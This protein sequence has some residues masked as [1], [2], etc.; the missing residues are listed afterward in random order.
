MQDQA[1][2]YQNILLVPRYSELTSRSK[3]KTSVIFLGRVFQ[4]PVIPAN[5]ESVIDEKI[6]KYLSENGYFYIYHR[7]S[8]LDNGH[9]STC[10]LVELAN[11]EKWKTIS[12][13]IG[14]NGN[15]LSLLDMMKSFRI[16]F[17]TIDVA[18]GH[19]IL[20]KEAIG[21]IKKWFPKTSI[22]A[23]NVATWEGVKDLALW[24]ADCVKVGIGQG[25]ICTTRFETGFSV[26]M[27]SC[28]RECSYLENWVPNKKGVPCLMKRPYVPIIADGGIQT[29]G[30]IAKALVAGADMVMCG[31]LFAGC[32]DSPARFATN[33]K[34]VY[35]GSASFEAKGIDRHIE[36]KS[37]ECFVDVPYARQLEKIK[38]AL[39]SSISYAGGCDLSAFH[40][41]EAATV[42]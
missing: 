12:I 29:R 25:S 41:V 42:K 28:V 13:S 40:D 2:S 19:H 36:G 32:V 9:L 27:F 34:K 31:N 18:H 6:A 16:D 22:I 14:T 30:D 15:D 38:E 8:D 26:P 23:G 35:F 37:V 39:R 3:A 1:V 5:M 24:G 21:V 10:Q 4:L 7:D 11:K 33:G 17:I 20:V